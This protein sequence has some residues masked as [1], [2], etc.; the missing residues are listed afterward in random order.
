MRS[1]RYGSGR[2]SGTP[3]RQALEGGGRQVARGDGVGPGVQQPTGLVQVVAD[4]EPPLLDASDGEATQLGEVDGVGGA[5]GG[6]QCR[7]ELGEGG[8]RCREGGASGGPV[9]LGP[10]ALGLP[11]AGLEQTARTGRRSDA[12]SLVP[13][14]TNWW[15]SASVKQLMA[16]LDE[17]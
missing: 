7:L 3:V 9:G 15:A 6:G 8:A 14:A 17:A 4:H 2:S 11:Q 13:W 16:A 5:P 10:V 1:P 12:R